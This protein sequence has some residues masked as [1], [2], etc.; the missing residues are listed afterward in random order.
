MRTFCLSA[1]GTL[2]AAANIPTIPIAPGV[3]M[4]MAGLGTWQYNET[5]AEQA[6][7]DALANGY[8]HIDCAYGYNNQVGVGKALAASSRARESYFITTKIP[9]GLNATTAK[10]NFDD[11]LAQ[12]GL[13][14]VDLLLVHYPASWS[15]VGGKAMRQEQWKAMEGFVKAGKVK[16]LGVSHYCRRH[17]EDV[18]EVATVPI[19]VNQVQYHVGMGSATTSSDNATDYKS[20]M[21]SKGITYQGFSPL[22][23]PCGT[24]ELIDGPLVTNIGKKYGKSGAQVSL[25][26]QVMQGIPVIPKTNSVPYML[27]NIDLF[28]WELSDVD[29]ATLNAATS[30]AVA[31]DGTGPD[32]T[33]GDC[34]VL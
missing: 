13:D 15:G 24:T 18:L 16:A 3:H 2:A 14:Y 31:G 17:V 11:G 23:G 22:C 6:V 7:A 1:V 34:A 12:L 29:V 10:A 9:G 8:T 33:S 27:E 30:P 4:P 28:D 25:K 19:A 26:W 32:A 5:V 21:A 20:W